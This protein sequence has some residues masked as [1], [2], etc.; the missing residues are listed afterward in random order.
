MRQVTSQDNLK[1]L[2]QRNFA[3]DR[4]ETCLNVDLDLMKQNIYENNKNFMTS[5]SVNR[6][7][8]KQQMQ[9]PPK[10]HSQHYISTNIN[11]PTL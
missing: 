2:L 5:K 10:W 6:Q 4:N 7:N 8:W 3:D 11:M 1:S 9:I